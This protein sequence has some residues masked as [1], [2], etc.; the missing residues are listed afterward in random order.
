MMPLKSSRLM[1][2]SGLLLL[3]ISLSGCGT[4]ES[5]PPPGAPKK[6]PLPGTPV[7]KQRSS[8]TVVVPQEQFNFSGKKDPFRAYVAAAKVK[9]PLPQSSG[10]QLPLQM[11][12]V[13]QFKVI[14]IITGLTENRAMVLDPAG[15]SFIIKA[16]TLIGPRN[17]RVLSITPRACEVIEQYRENGKI[18][19]RVVKLALPRKE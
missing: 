15:K 1:V 5:S 19:K 6:G 12:E 8:A 4:M 17:G 18:G 14:G 7:Q 3:A 16:G 10:K 11:Y 13:N 2:I 9:L